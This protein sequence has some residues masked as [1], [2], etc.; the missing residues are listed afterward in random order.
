MHAPEIYTVDSIR[1][2]KRFISIRSGE[3]KEPIIHM[4]ENEIV[5]GIGKK[6]N[7]KLKKG[8]LVEIIDAKAIDVPASKGSGF[9]KYALL[10]LSGIAKITAIGDSL[11]RAKIV[12]S[13]REIKIGQSKARM[14]QP[15][16]TINVNGYTADTVARM[17]SL[18]MIRYAMD[19]M[20]MI[21][22]YSYV[23]VDKGSAQ[24]YNTGDGVAIWEEDKTDK[25]LPPRLL[26]RGVIARATQ[27]ESS[28]L[29]RELYSNSRRIE[30]G[31]KVS[32]THRA[33]IVK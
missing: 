28:V 17:D 8:D 30:V 31:H 15:L 1:N 6:I 3:K 32:V 33:N 25:T 11:S 23:L 9:T 21:G 22:A 16:K 10:R 29:I 26:G 27:N 20:L 7:D 2:D 13:F 4:P 14:K 5:V 12:T 24:G 18:A 19:P